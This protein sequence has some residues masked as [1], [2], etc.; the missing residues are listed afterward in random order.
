MLRAQ[1]RVIGDN[2]RHVGLRRRPGQRKPQIAPR[3]LRS[4]VD[5]KYLPQWLDAAVRAGDAPLQFQGLAV[6][7]IAVLLVGPDGAGR[8]N[9]HQRPVRAAGGNWYQAEVAVAAR[10]FSP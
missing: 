8:G 3:G 7:E 5:R 4:D 1:V 2:A 6:D 9:H 10:L